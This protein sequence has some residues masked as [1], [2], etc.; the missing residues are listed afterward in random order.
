[1]GTV[2][3]TRALWKYIKYP[4]LNGPSLENALLEEMCSACVLWFVSW[5][6]VNL[7]ELMLTILVLK[8]YMDRNYCST[9]SYISS[10][11][12]SVMDNHVDS[13]HET[14]LGLICFGQC[15]RFPLYSLLL[16]SIWIFSILFENYST[17]HFSFLCK[18]DSHLAPML[19][20]KQVILCQ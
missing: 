12:V 6:L 17:T 15:A 11:V 3:I 1:M 16:G 5:K 10:I 18:A 4:R 13:T 8:Y 19:W 2:L 14:A 20:Y 7:K 9:S